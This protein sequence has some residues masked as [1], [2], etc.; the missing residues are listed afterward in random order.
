MVGKIITKYK[1]RIPK[2]IHLGPTV[3]KTENWLLRLHRPHHGWFTT[4]EQSGLYELAERLTGLAP[5][6]NVATNATILD[7]GCAEGLIGLHFLGLG[8]AL[9][10]GVDRHSRFVETAQTIARLQPKARFFKFDL[11]VL[12]DQ[13]PDGLLSSYDIVLCLCVAHKLREPELFLRRVAGLCTGYLALQL[14]AVVIDDTRSGHRQVDTGKLLDELGFDLFY[15]E[16][17]ESHTKP[18]RS[19]PSLLSRRI[20]RKRVEEGH[21]HGERATAATDQS[22]PSSLQG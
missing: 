14:P 13:I 8:G 12:A 15:E 10:H 17:S 6:E 11:N 18:L 16:A 9:L 2:W 5:L 20:Y 22:D 7:L 21:E 1:S 3:G 4:A 19:P